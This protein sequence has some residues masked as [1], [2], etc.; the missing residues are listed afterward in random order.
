MKM[1]LDLD[2]GIDDA[3]ALAYAIAHPDIELIGVTGTYGNVTIEQGM[4]NTRALLKL[5]GQ[6]DIPVYA[7]VEIEGFV[8]SEAS[9]RIHGTNGVGE[10]NIATDNAESAGEAVDFLIE[11]AAKYGEDLVV[12]PTGAQTTTAKALEKDEALRG[13]RM[14]TMGGALTVPGNVS[15]AAEAN[16]SQDPVSSNSVYQL[17]EDMTM[18]GLDV[19]MQTQLTR[20]EADSWRGTAAGDAFADMA[21]YYI[22]AYQENNP[23]M[24]GCALH[25]PLAVAVAVDPDLVDC[26]ILPL[27][28]DTEGP[29]VGRTIGR[30]DGS[31]VETRVAV[32]VDV[33]AFVPDFIDKL[34]QLFARL[35]Q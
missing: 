6:P 32:G 7:G 30:W 25:D 26:L 17:A 11:S 3:F 8:V 35:A 31:E 21:G 5:L 22:D 12:V 20:A 23:H 16:I 27:Q 9:A 33:D 28:V 18:V 15:P 34:G 24:D 2:T 4:A 10:V 29:T 19:T 14:V 13:I 1:I